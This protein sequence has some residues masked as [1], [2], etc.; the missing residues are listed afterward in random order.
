M[1]CEQ[2]LRHDFFK[3]I[4]SKKEKQMDL[5]AL[6]LAPLPIK[7][8]TDSNSP[9]M[10]KVLVDPFEKASSP[11]LENVPSIVVKGIKTSSNL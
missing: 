6:D 4:L 8:N 7:K 9:D 5:L 10:Y 11:K 1:T 2:A 3:D